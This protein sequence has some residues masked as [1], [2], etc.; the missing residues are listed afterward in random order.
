MIGSG[1]S[2][3]VVFSFYTTKCITTGEGGAIVT[4]HKALAERMRTM[5]LHGISRDVFDRYTSNTA[6]WEYDIVAAGFKYNMPDIMAAI[7]IVQI[8]RAEEMRHN[9]MKIAEYYDRHLQSERIGLPVWS[10]HGSCHL[11]VIRVPNRNRMIEDMHLSGVSCSVHFKPLHLMTY[12]KNYARGEYPGADS[13]FSSCMSLPIY[14]KMTIEQ[15]DYVVKAV[16]TCMQ[17]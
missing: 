16:K 15:A 10:K 5:R 6:G 9:R 2:T 11:Y 14:S 8:A 4:K 3:A 17:R 12:W 13:I 1:L 7:G